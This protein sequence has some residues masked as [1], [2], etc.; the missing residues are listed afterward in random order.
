MAKD[1]HVSRQTISK[2]ESDLSLPNME[3]ILLMCELYHVSITELLGI[4]ENKTDLTAQLFDSMNLVASNLEKEKS[5]RKIFDIVLVSVCMVS[6][7]LN[8]YNFIRKP[9]Q[10]IIDKGVTNV[11]QTQEEKVFETTTIDVLGYHFDEMMMDVNINA[12]TKNRNSN[13]IV[14]C[15]M[16]DR[17]GNQYEYNLQNSKI[18]EYSY[19]GQIPLMD[20]E[21]IVFEMNTEGK[22]KSEREEE[23][24]YLRNILE[25]YI[26][27]GIPCEWNETSSNKIHYD[28][29]K[30]Y[31][32]PSLSGMLGN[33]SFDGKI[34][35]KM[36]L[37]IRK[38]NSNG[39]YTVL[40]DKDIDLSRTGDI[41]L[42]KKIEKY[43]DLSI[44]VQSEIDGYICDVINVDRKIFPTSTFQETSD[45]YVTYVYQY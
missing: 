29:I 6:L 31:V 12:S 30:Y 22:I 38:I 39:P 26:C 15:Y 7:C 23:C 8:V 14:T 45:G 41:E 13:S 18:N 3:T 10:V 37:V 42:D 33:V 9:Q 40:I 20:Y 16:V 28:Q 19:T 4:D 17:K 11:T 44:S 34:R 25:K 21:K 24:D 43:C 27:L 35:G 2:Y 32:H 1:L 36:H 5:R